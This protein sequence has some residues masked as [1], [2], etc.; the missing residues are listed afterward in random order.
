MTETR[1]PTL[2]TRLLEEFDEEMRATRK[3]LEHVPDDK[4]SWKPH[5]KS[6]SLGKL[7]NHVAAAPGVAAIILKRVGTKPPEA[8]TKAELLTFF[9]KNVEA[10]RE[11]LAA[12]SEDRLEGNML[13]TFTIEK[14]VWSVLRGRG[15]MNHLIHH[16]GQLSVYLRLLDV[17]VPGMYGPSADEK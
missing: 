2:K 4:F 3:M 13:V 9:D 10:C 1:K 15:L 5:E 11:Q 16:R 6:F 17:A 7:A 14:P 12:M 8:A